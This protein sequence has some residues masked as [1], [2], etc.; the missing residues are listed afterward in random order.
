MSTGL[1]PWSLSC[2]RGCFSEI[3]N[4]VKRLVE[5]KGVD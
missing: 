4:E 3:V 1:K 5:V 2:S